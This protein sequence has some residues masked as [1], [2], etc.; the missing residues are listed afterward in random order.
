MITDALPTW[1]WSSTILSQHQDHLFLFF[2]WVFLCGGLLVSA[3][4]TN[5]LCKEMWGSQHSLHFNLEKE[6]KARCRNGLSKLAGSA[7][8]LWLLTEEK[9]NQG[10]GGI[11]FSKQYLSKRKNSISSRRGGLTAVTIRKH[12]QT[13][14]WLRKTTCSN[15]R[16]AGFLRAF[17]SGVCVLEGGQGEMPLTCISL[18]KSIYCP[19]IEEQRVYTHSAFK[20]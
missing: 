19:R 20:H 7:S 4:K 15:N 3:Y 2:P 18:L 11:Y 10:G 9:P 12:L 17:A 13:T 6:K 5:C 16:T 1:P 8:W 14:T